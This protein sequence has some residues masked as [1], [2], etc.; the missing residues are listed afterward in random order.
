MWTNGTYGHVAI[1][2]HGDVHNIYS[3]DQNW[4]SSYCKEVHH[5]GYSG[6]WGV[7]R[8][9]FGGDDVVIGWLDKA[10]GGD[11]TLYVKGWAINKSHPDATV[12]I[13][14][15]MDGPAGVGVR[16]ADGI[17]ANQPRP[18]VNE[19]T[20]VSGNHGFEATIP[21]GVTGQ[22]TFYAHGIN[23]T[24]NPVLENSSET[25][26]VIREGA[27]GI[28]SYV[29]ITELTGSGY[30]VNIGV[31]DSSKISTLAV[32]VWT[33]KS[34][35]T[36]SQ[37]QDDL[38]PAWASQNRATKIDSKTYRYYVSTVDH[39]NESGTYCND[40]YAFD[41]SGNIIDHWS[42]ETNHRTIANV[43]AAII[44]NV[45]I[46]NVTYQGYDVIVSVNDPDI[47]TSALIYLSVS[48]VNVT[49]YEL[50]SATESLVV[51]LSLVTHPLLFIL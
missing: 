26:T 2:L 13:H 28:I 36:D 19:A 25:T 9:D 33:Q 1:F 51:P 42:I 8:P 27:T 3:M 22:H 40:V 15:Y 20:G 5:E 14:I 43:P 39:N 41:S 10:I 31:N 45:Q 46:T 37:A 11:G 48:N 4:G 44:N 21:I 29:N 50:P 16:V 49:E 34:G 17:I 23:G 35:Q 30:T 47:V 12:E 6:V 38:N 32:P 7:I 18:D 24:T